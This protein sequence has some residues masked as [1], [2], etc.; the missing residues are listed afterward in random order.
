MEVMSLQ[1]VTSLAIAA[2][3]SCRGRP[4]VRTLSLNGKLISSYET[5]QDWWAAFK[6]SDS[7]EQSCNLYLLEYCQFVGREPDQLVGER[8]ARLK[9]DPDDRMDEKQLNRWHKKLLARHAPGFALTK[10]TAV[11][12]FYKYNNKPLSISKFPR[13]DP[14]ER[15][16]YRRLRREEILRMLSRFGSRYRPR[17][18]ILVGAESGLR[19]KHLRI[20]RLK[21]LVR[22]ED[23]SRDGITC[24]TWRDLEAAKPPVRISL[25]KR[26]YYGRKKAGIT[27]VCADAIKA[28]VEDLKDRESRG[29]PVGPET[30]IFPVYIAT[31]RADVAHAQTRKTYL[32]SWHVTGDRI[33][34][35][36]S[37][38]G[39]RNGRLIPGVVEKVEVDC[40]TEST[41]QLDMRILRQ[42]AGLAY[43][44]KEERPVSIHSLRKYQRS[45]LDAAG[46]NSIMANVITGHS[47]AVE[48]HYSG[49][50][51]LDVEEIRGAY[52]AV[53]QKI[54]I[55][56]DVDK[57]SLTMMQSKLKLLDA[58]RDRLEE[59]ETKQ[60]VLESVMEQLRRKN[61]ATIQYYE[62]QLARQTSMGRTG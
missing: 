7:Y 39:S 57:S 25:P 20:I 61:E 15:R 27:F 42:R 47:N 60:Q 19:I 11:V 46:V 12:S 56:E 44:E 62:R 3:V 18:M 38:P 8:K 41:L 14:G 49:V 35:R 51:H 55:S 33:M 24:A 58:T 36:E 48:E 4:R 59:L 22:E 17:N 43:D 23:G 34:L 13:V 29:E 9:A 26:E 40:A 5:V 2:T 30:P 1:D 28:L 50:R 21:S 53:M 32:D 52:A 54:Q 6:H 10:Y 16:E 31:V 37:G 45:T